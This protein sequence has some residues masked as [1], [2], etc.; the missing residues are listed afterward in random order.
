MT[1]P[2]DLREMLNGEEV[3]IINARAPTA[4]LET[5]S[6]S[7]ITDINLMLDQGRIVGINPAHNPGFEGPVIDL[8]GG[9][10]LPCFTDIHTHLDK[11]HIWPRRQN[12]NGTFEGAL[13]S[14]MED[15]EAN[16]TTEDVRARMTFSLECAYHHGTTAIRTHLDSP[17]KQAAI[18]WPLFEEIRSEWSDR[19]ELQAASLFGIDAMDDEA[20]LPALLPHMT[21]AGGVLGAV[22]YPV[23]RL[24]EHLETLFK[25]A[26]DRNLTLDFHADETR[27]PSSDCLLKIAE[28][29]KRMKF[30]GRVLI[31]HCCSLARQRADTIDRTLDVVA[32]AGLGVVSL[33]LC[34]LYLQDRLYDGHAPITPHWRGVTL[35]HEMKARGIPVM[36]ASDNTRDPFYA[37]GDLDMLEVYRE[38]TRIAHLD[39]PVADWPGAVT[40][41]S[42]AF[43]EFAASSCLSEGRP[44]DIIL[45]RAR[46][47]TELFARPQHDRIVLR[48]GRAIDTALPD[49]RVLD[50]I[51]GEPKHD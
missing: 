35:L 29:A 12:P 42:A 15:R 32:E 30:D 16:W 38:A 31:G 46:S 26:I 23:P 2:T 37:Y 50:P 9:L 41:T 18:S 1:W 8:D 4:L 45:F 49:Y 27:D 22:A 39:H 40:K 20:F 14:V 19:I 6:H 13:S 24:E 44:A 11:G 48:G 33:P 10:I 36:I 21:K 28:T 5:A 25:T 3:L 43:G 17:G 34:N 51:V 47:W 7:E